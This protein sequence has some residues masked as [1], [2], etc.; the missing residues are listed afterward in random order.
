MVSFWNWFRGCG[1]LEAGK[2]DFRYISDE[3]STRGRLPGIIRVLPR[4]QPNF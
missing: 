2:G 3:G 1:Q 4:S